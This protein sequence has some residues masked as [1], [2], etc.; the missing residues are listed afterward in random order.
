M[1]GNEL[2]AAWQCFG[3]ADPVQN[4]EVI[5]DPTLG[6][7]TVATLKG[8]FA[9]TGGGSECVTLDEEKYNMCLE[10]GN[11]RD[12]EKRTYARKCTYLSSSLRIVR[13]ATEGPSP[14]LCAYWRT[15]PEAA[16]EEI[17]QLAEQTVRKDGGGGAYEDED[18]GMTTWERRQREV[19]SDNAQTEDS[20]IP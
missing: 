4:V 3:E 16:M 10:S 1:Y 13:P 18:D 7:H 8:K 6:R 11:P 2:I 17:G 9:S 12:T 14:E 15:T 5:A 20:G 19:D